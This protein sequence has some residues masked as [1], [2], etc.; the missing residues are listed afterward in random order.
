MF[1]YILLLFPLLISFFFKGKDQR[2]FIIHGYA[3]GT[4]YSIK[5][6][7]RDSVITKQSV[8]SILSVID[9]SMSLYKPYSLISKFNDSSEGLDLDPHFV[10][11]MQKSFEVYKATSGKFDVTVAPLVQAWGFGPK[12]IAKFPDSAEVK[13]LLKCVG[14]NNLSLKGNHLSKRKSCIKIDLNGIGQGYSVDVV[15]DYLEYKGIKAFVVEIGGE[16]RIKGPK[17]D[18]TAMRI[19]IEG[20]AVSA[21]SE[22]VIRHVIRA[23]NG[24][25]TTAG[26][27]RKYLQKGGRKV[28]HLIDPKTGYPLDNALISVTIYAK[29]GLTADGYDSPIMAMGLKEALDFASKKGM[30]AY[31]IYHK[32]DGSVADTLTRGF[33]KMIV[34]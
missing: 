31:I 3:Q 16:L 12:P 17:P 28:A 22:P 15:A 6:F 9:S 21:N 1:K 2:E 29:D 30:E 18:G 8:D 5:Y 24:A 4:D 10:V 7:A 23:N 19:G 20:P 34:E 13:Q 26:N 33:R 27:Y 32:S 25:I 11:V 14:M